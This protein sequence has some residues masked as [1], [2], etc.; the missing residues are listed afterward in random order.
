MLDDIQANLFNAANER[1]RS[2]IVDIKTLDEMHAFFASDRIG[3]TRSPVDLINDPEFEKIKGKFAVTPRC[4]PFED[5][6][7]TVLVGRSY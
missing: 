6:G 7:Q 2:N 5:E 3:F 1:M 4:I